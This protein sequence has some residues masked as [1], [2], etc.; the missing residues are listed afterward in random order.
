MRSIAVKLAAAALLATVPAQALAAHVVRFDPNSTATVSVGG[1]GRVGS[2]NGVQDPYYGDVGSTSHSADG[3][4]NA[5]T[6]STSGN[7]ASSSANLSDGTVHG[8]AASTQNDVAFAES[9]FKD[10]VY[11]TNTTGSAL[12]LTVRFD[13]DGSVIGASQAFDQFAGGYSIFYLANCSA[14]ANSL[15][16][17]ITYANAD[18][19][20]ADEAA[21]MLF[22]TNGIYHFAE[23]TGISGPPNPLDVSYGQTF[24]NGFMTGFF[25]TTLSIPTG[26]TSLGVGATLHLDCRFGST[27]D[28][29]NT[30]AFTFGALPTGLSFTSESGTFLSALET[31]PIDPGSGGGNGVPEPATW[32][33][34][35]LGFGLIGAT[36]RSRRRLVLAA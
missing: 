9:Y 31:G 22:S 7:T 18:A 15:G 16:Q 4:T 19:R 35:I 2:V 17:Q 6:T 23:Y 25:Q 8:F 21:Y 5:A 30:G 27:C 11:F 36:A 12:N 26:L 14:C 3:W 13:L 29:G 10:T 24:D 33:M 1:G 20:V 32:A 28:F 34:M